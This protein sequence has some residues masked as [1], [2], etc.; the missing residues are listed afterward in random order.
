MPFELCPGT[1]PH[2]SRT[3]PLGVC[4]TRRSL[5]V[6]LFLNTIGRELP[7]V[8]GRVL[9]KH[10]L[11]WAPTELGVLASVADSTRG[12]EETPVPTLVSTK[13][14]GSVS[15]RSGLELAS[16]LWP[17]GGLG[18]FAGLCSLSTLSPVASG[19]RGHSG[20]S[21]QRKALRGGAGSRRRSSHRPGWLGP[22]GEREQQGAPGSG[23]GP[24]TREA[25]EGCLPGLRRA[26]Q[27][28]VEDR[29][30]G[31]RNPGHRARAASVRSSP[32]TG[33]A[34]APQAQSA[35]LFVSDP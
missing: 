12:G 25:E 2:S 5:W 33:M 19:G 1:E 18:A 14:C 11:N 17:L 35:S 24:G 30:R 4:A 32:V 6:W 28:S 27:R 29:D 7:K 20:T 3:F 13:V 21:V 34:A 22:V 31:W 23:E 15:L 10:R 8:A 16:H 26:T 9:R